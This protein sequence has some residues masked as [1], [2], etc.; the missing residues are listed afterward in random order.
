MGI[1]ELN[2]LCESFNNSK[3]GGEAIEGFDLLLEGYKKAFGDRYE[4][5]LQCMLNHNNANMHDFLSE[6]LNK[7]AIKDEKTMP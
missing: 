6:H 2:E 1:K 4:L 3:C 7:S 5:F